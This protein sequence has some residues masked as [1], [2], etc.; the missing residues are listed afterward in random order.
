MPDVTSANTGEPRPTELDRENVIAALQARELFLTTIL[1][2]LESFFTVDSKWRCAFANQAGA[3]LA[4]VGAAELLGADLRDYVPAE[5]R[6]EVCARLGVA[7]SGRVRSTV[8][9][10]DP[11][12]R[13]YA[14][15]P[16]ADGG[17]AVYVRDVGALR[18]IRSG[19]PA[20]RGGAA[21]AR[22][23]VPL[24]LHEH[25]RRRGSAPA[26]L[27]RG[28]G[29]RLH[30]RRR[31][32]SLRAAHH[33]ERGIGP[34]STRKRGLRHRRGPVPRRVRE[35]HREWRTLHVRDLLRAP[36][37][38]LSDHRRRARGSALRYR[39]RRRHRA[40]AGG[41]DVARERGTLPPPARHH[42][43]GSGLPGRRRDH[44]LDEP[45]RGA[46]PGQAAGGLPG[47][48]LRR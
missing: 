25:D 15:Y 34:G 20:R 2:S 1:G 43:P 9:A 38:A 13:I 41:G 11:G 27:R 26:R 45:R 29:G 3:D 28:R 37:A 12:R 7:M 36:A 39:L 10:G 42:A 46:D 6:D 30:R 31:Q 19:A 14:A 35:G 23:E 33:H 24:P 17:L 16:L 18:P 47:L 32:S 8:E 44:R 5:A 22:G 40:Q 21:R 48:D 4:G